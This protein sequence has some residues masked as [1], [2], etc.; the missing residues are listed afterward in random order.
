[1]TFNTKGEP[2]HLSDIQKVFR[3]NRP[4]YKGKKVPFVYLHYLGTGYYVISDLTVSDK[5]ERTAADEAVEHAL[6][7]IYQLMIHEKVVRQASNLSALKE[8]GLWPVPRKGKDTLRQEL[9]I[10]VENESENDHSADIFT[11]LKIHKD[12]VPIK[13]LIQGKLEYIH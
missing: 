13:P 11:R 9:G 2:V 3:V 7:E 12:Q 5:E 4:T 6:T 8:I 1:V 10:T